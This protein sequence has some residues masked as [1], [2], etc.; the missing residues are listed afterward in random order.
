MRLLIMQFSPAS[1]HFIPLRSKYS[2]QNPVLI[3]PQSILF[4]TV[5]EKFHTHTEPQAKLYPPFFFLHFNL[6]GFRLLPLTNKGV[7]DG[8]VGIINA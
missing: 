3:H 5:K 1:Y 4:P 7:M 2:P 6:R 8:R